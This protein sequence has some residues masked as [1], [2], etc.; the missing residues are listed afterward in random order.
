[1]LNKLYI[2][3]RLTKSPEHKVANEL[4]ITKFT[5]ATSRGYG[6]K[7]T[8]EFIN[9][10]AFGTTASNIVKFVKKGHLILI[11]GYLK[12]SKWEYEGKTYYRTEAVV[13][14]STFLPNKAGI[15]TPVVEKETKKPAKKAV[16]KKKK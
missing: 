10:I 2:L 14:K 1:M 6:A 13:E 15:E 9:C 8:T 7:Q 5:I 3:G 4:D 11:E 16:A 12:T